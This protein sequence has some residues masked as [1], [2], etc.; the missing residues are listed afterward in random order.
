MCLAIP[1]KIIS[2]NNEMAQIDFL[3]IKKQA[4]ISLVDFKI[5]VNDYVL[6]H[7]GFVIQKITTEEAI[8][9]IEGVKE[10]I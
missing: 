2:I 9:S 7:A 10:M 4:N 8:D 5:A 3:G 6:V 1:G